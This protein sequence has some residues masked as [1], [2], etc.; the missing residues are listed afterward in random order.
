MGKER[1]IHASIYGW[2]GND[3]IIRISTEW[4]IKRASKYWL[5]KINEIYKVFDQN[6]MPIGIF[7]YKNIT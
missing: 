5:Y 4:F 7:T 1:K 3:E 2:Q 6:L